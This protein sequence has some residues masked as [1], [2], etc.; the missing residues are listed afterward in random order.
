MKRIYKE[1]RCP[2]LICR[3][4]IAY[5]I[6]TQKNAIAVANTVSSSRPTE[7]IIEH[8]KRYKVVDQEKCVK[9]GNCLEVCPAEYDAVIKISPVSELPESELPTKDTE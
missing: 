7:A 9:C 5:Y 4:L 1:K 8:P 3:N 6:I 2:A